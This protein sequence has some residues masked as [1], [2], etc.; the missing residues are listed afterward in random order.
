VRWAGRMAGFGP[1]RPPLSGDS[2]A[3]QPRRF[4]PLTHPVAITEHCVIGDQVRLPSAWCDIA[5]CGSSFADPAALGEIDNRSRAARAG[6]AQ[7][8]YGR[9]VCPDCQRHYRAESTWAGLLPQPGTT[10]DRRASAGAAQP[11]GAMDP[12]VPSGGSQAATRPHQGRHHRAVPW[13]R[14]LTTLAGHPNGW[15]TPYQ[16]ASPRHGQM[17]GQAGVCPPPRPDPSHRRS[18]VSSGRPG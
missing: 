13:P 15:T 11:T 5:G 12:A 8:A 16:A 18:A 2:Q 14:V 17:P 3:P 10:S 1:I 6:W 9:L 4:D 7:D